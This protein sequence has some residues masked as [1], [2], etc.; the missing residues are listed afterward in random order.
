MISV[1]AQQL[2]EAVEQCLG[3]IGY[4]SELL[5]RDYP[6]AD[7]EQETR[8]PL[9]A[10]AQEPPSYRNACFGVVFGS[11]EESLSDYWWLGAPQLL[12]IRDKSVYRWKVASGHKVEFIEEIQ[13]DNLL[14]TFRRHE[15]EWRP[16]SIL[17]ARSI[18]YNRGAL[19]LDFYDLGLLPAIESAV[20]PRLDRLLRD[21]LWVS[22]KTYREHNIGEIDYP[23]L[24]RLIFRLLAAKLLGDRKY[25]GNWLQSDPQK[26]LAEVERHYFRDDP[27][28][29]VLSDINTQHVAWDKIR[30]SFHLQNISLEA[31]AYIYENTLVDQSKRRDYGIHSTP[32]EVAEYIVQHLPFE[33]LDLGERTIFEPFAGHGAFLIASLGR[34]RA[35][36]P[37]GTDALR[38][39]RYFVEMLSGMELDAFAVEIARLSLMLADYPN[40][41]GWKLLLEDAFV[42]PTVDDRLRHSN[43]VLCN[44]PFE[45]FTPEERAYYSGAQLRSTN[46]A[47]D[48]LL[49]VLGHPPAMFG[50]VLPSSFRDGIAYRE[51][52]RRVVETYGEVELVSMPE[53][54]FQHSSAETILLIAWDQRKGP[55]LNVR[56]GSVTKPS[57]DDFKRAG[58]TGQWA[59]STLVR[60]DVA[61]D[62]S[63]WLYPLGSIWSTLAN[64]ATLGD[65]A[66]VHRGIE[67]KP[68]LKIDRAQLISP[69]PREGFA[70]GLSQV[71]PQFEPYHVERSVYLNMD[72]AVMRRQAYRLPWDKPKVI[73][74]AARLSR[75]AWVVGAVPDTDGLVAS[76]NFHGIWPREE[77]PVEVLAAI[78]NGP[79]ANAFMSA[80]RTKHHNRKHTLAEIP[81]PRLTLKGMSQI[82]ALVR[83]YREVRSEWIAYPSR[84][85]TLAARCRDL[86]LQIDLRVLA[87][88][89]LPR[90]QQ[91]ELLDYFAGD[92][93]PGPVPFNGYY[94]TNYRPFIS[95]DGAE[96][97]G[98]RWAETSQEPGE[99]Y[100][101][102]EAAAMLGISLTSLLHLLEQGDL[103]FTQGGPHPF[104]Q[105]SDLRAYEEHRR[106]QNLRHLDAMRALSDG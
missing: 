91:Q 31:L 82:V 41:N 58:R 104:I 75:G 102:I 96:G 2:F 5:H 100:T 105:A 19:Q 23:S 25:P 34:L 83:A 61:A 6:F 26:I 27:A 49:R 65:V 28:R 4:T 103:P 46:K 29:P 21:T 17:R 45:D 62:R 71:R 93:R 95:T 54:T 90:D 43:I 36:L 78:L 20:R 42:S 55:R 47:A 92:E 84:G 94:P 101:L 56:T 88:Y 66:D 35:L 8:I 70:A 14:S 74:N 30:L 9:A 73:V 60:S 97:D 50:F 38:R 77:W 1:L 85:A 64:N 89:D 86:L 69:S 57:Y 72:P 99:H 3:A 32:P 22:E 76:Q 39:H 79:V 37:K 40:P 11:D 53:N 7:A 33:Y 48:I 51:A 87:A 24:F 98:R 15:S 68:P 52:R 10:F 44:P 67:Y 13:A 59:A 16:E 81:L 12:Q 80:R 18:A 63:L 106:E